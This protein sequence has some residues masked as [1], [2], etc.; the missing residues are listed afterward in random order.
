MF[1]AAL[2][3]LFA[4]IRN[5]VITIC[6]NIGLERVAAGPLTTESGDYITT[7]SGDIL[8]QE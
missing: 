2:L 3:S 8:K 6:E 7:E 1:D 5:D 4:A